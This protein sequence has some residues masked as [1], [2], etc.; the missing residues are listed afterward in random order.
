MLEFVSQ[1]EAG[2]WKG[3]K[4]EDGEHSFNFSPTE[5]NPVVVSDRNIALPL[6]AVIAIVLA[7]VSG[8]VWFMATLNAIREDIKAVASDRWTLS[9]HK[10][11]AHQMERKNPSLIVPDIDDVRAKVRTTTP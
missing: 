8:T 7:F 5:A 9:E 10:E 2:D 4:R 1:A 6:W 3:M 11:W